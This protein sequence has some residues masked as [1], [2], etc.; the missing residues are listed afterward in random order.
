MV[1]GC[2]GREM[3]IMHVIPGDLWAG[4]ESQVFY[5]IRQLIGRSDHDVIAV[6]FNKKELYM[7]LCGEGLSVQVIDESS[8]NSLVIC[9]NLRTILNNHC[10][11]IV[12]VHEHK[13][14]ILTFF[15]KLLAGSRCKI[16]RTLHGQTAAPFTFKY[17]A[18]SM[19]LQLENAL[20]RFQTDAI[21]AVSRDVES[22]LKKKYKNTRIC[23]INNAVQVSSEGENNEADKRTQFGIGDDELWIGTA[24]R[25]VGVK[26]LDMLIDAAKILNDNA[27]K[28]IKISIFGDGTLKDKLQKKIERYDL[29]EN[30]YLHGHHNDFIEIAKSLDVF[31]LTSLNEGLPMS[32]LEAMS[33]GAVPV[34]T[35]VGGMQEVIEDMKSGYLVELNDA[36]QLADVFMRLYND[37]EL[38][39]SMGNNAKKRVQEKYSIANNVAALLELYETIK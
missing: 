13:S 12:H 2:A 1:K 3:L 10:P 15:A 23:Q 31:S 8:N 39:A 32:L 37:R 27:F 4:A 7:R 33:V 6:L 16:I 28:G 17:L 18:A 24:A 14:H 30:V 5:T 9:S 34:C 22:V 21:I 36:S 20:L 11:D 26:N 35:K 19:I 25:L 38:L 29:T